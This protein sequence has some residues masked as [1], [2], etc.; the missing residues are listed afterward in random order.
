MFRGFADSSHTYKFSFFHLTLKY[1][2][3]FLMALISS[4]TV[5][6]LDLNLSMVFV[7]HNL[8]FLNSLALFLTP[9][10]HDKPH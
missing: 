6:P 7:G 5:S 3:I 4:A 10:S 2:I 1:I 9:E 8:S